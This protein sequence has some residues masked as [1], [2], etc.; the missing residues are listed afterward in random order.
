[1]FELQE[2]KCLGCYR[3]QSKL[4]RPLCVDHCHV[5]GKVRGLLC[6]SCNLMLGYANDNTQVLANL[7]KYLNK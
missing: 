5:T 7:I 4:K 2:G 3:H 6:V 1:M